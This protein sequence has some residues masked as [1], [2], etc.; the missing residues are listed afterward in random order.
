MPI[1]R[2]V[3]KQI[4]LFGGLVLLSWLQR[5]ELSSGKQNRTGKFWYPEGSVRPVATG[6]VAFQ[7]PTGA[8][9]TPIALGG[10]QHHNGG[11]RI[12][13]GS[14]WL[15]YRAMPGSVRFNY[16]P[17]VV[18]KAMTTGKD[19]QLEKFPPF[20]LI[21]GDLA[22][23]FSQGVANDEYEALLA[24]G[25][26]HLN[27]RDVFGANGGSAGVSNPNRPGR[28]IPWTRR[29]HM[30]QPNNFDWIPDFKEGKPLSPQQLEQLVPWIMGDG[31]SNYFTD[32][33]PPQWHLLDWE[34]KYNDQTWTYLAD[35]YHRAYRDRYLMSWMGYAQMGIHRLKTFDAWS[36]VS[37]YHLT[38][39]V[40]SGNV[41]CSDG[42]PQHLENWKRLWHN[43]FWGVLQ[44]LHKTEWMRRN[45]PTVTVLNGYMTAYEDGAGGNQLHFDYY[46]LHPSLAENGP[47]WGLLAAR[48]APG[49]PGGFVAWNSA[50]A[51]EPLTSEQYAMCGMLRLSFHNPVRRSPR[52]QWVKPQ[53]SFDGGKTWLQQADIEGNLTFSALVHRQERG[54]DR[55]KEPVVRCLVTPEYVT[56]YAQNPYYDAPL[57]QTVK[58]RIPGVIEDF[59]TMHNVRKKV[60]NLVFNDREMTV[61]VAKRR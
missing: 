9:P 17:R 51:R 1:S 13:K 53:V 25:W 54:S 16:T 45:H 2:I 21:P 11:G 42:N 35:Y 34:F 26:S 30:T 41:N 59:V 55:V 12:D 43:D 31:V 29:A 50:H 5:G 36:Q 37:Y 28:D 19:L 7:P 15:E 52:Y 44:T 3:L 24:R 18:L 40:D 57:A 60:G 22:M 4:G 10:V 61:A 6:Y 49:Q 47:I 39:W 58:I 56:V 23:Y 32:G 33:Q 48:N 46:K 20:A 38:D 14:Y 8:A 27:S